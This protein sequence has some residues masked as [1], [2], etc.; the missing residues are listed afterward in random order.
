VKAKA[1]RPVPTATIG[2]QVREQL[3]TFTP[4]ERLVAR[5]LLAGYPIAGLESLP[6]LAE[7][8]GVTGP[9]VLRFVR[10]LG[11]EG[12]PHFQRSL[13]EEVQ[14]RIQ[15]PL[16]LYSSQMLGPGDAA[17]KESL[18]VFHGALDE[19]FASVPA[20]EF[21][22]VV[23]LLADE[24]RRAVFT[25]GRF[26]QLIAHYLYAQL[27]MVR[28]ECTLAGESFDPRVDQLIDV[29]PGDVVC[30]FDYRRYQDDT[31]TF[32]RHAAARGATVVL[33]TDPWLS[34][35]TDVADHVLTAYPDAPSPFD[36]MVAAFALAD[37][38]LAAVVTRLGERGKRRLQELEA[39]RAA[40]VADGSLTHTRRRKSKEGG[41]GRGRS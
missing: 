1:I 17:L 22:A 4:S 10:K 37:A 38:V 28:R 12:Y 26:S 13:R 33:F 16:S 40:A 36:S 3:E 8:A 21:R 41:H 9:T 35:A 27:R 11:Y 23:R 18:R 25:G 7:A 2:E 20:G 34:P 39:T 31:V 32:A 5:T 24:R 14:A 30:A 6:R 15:S 19:T 29:G